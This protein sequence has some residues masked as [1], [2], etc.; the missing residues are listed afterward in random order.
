MAHAIF[1]YRSDS[2]YDDLPSEYYQ[3][4]K[5]YLRTA[6]ETIGD[7][8]AYYE[9]TK[10][11]ATRGYFAVARVL[12][13]VPDPAIPNYWRAIIE[14]GQYLDFPCP[15][16]LHLA[17]GPAERDRVRPDGSF[18]S[19]AMQSAV[20][21]LSQGDFDRIVRHGLAKTSSEREP[22]MADEHATWSVAEAPPVWEVERPIREVLVN[23]PK[24]DAQF[25]RAV[26]AAY[27]SRC[28]LT[29]LSFINGGGAVEVQAAHI[30]PVE[31]GGPDA[32]GNGLALSAT[33][34]W[35]FDRGLVSLSDQLMILV[36]PKVN[37]VEG[38]GRLLLPA[39]RALVPAD[40][41]LR[42][43]RAFLRWHRERHAL[44]DYA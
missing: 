13:I 26:L 42:P 39:R 28:A 27:G 4:P 5:Q 35:M 20:R 38:L 19:G 16:P 40:E 25:R 30:R 24:R 7:W 1:A 33:V 6:R 9:P 41:R 2:P 37:D 22:S 44:Q 15:V 36:S 31:H 23:R 11:T 34:H 29:G 14:P 32:I 10:V 17:D 43:N 8:I 21:A 12:Q 3:F 18:G